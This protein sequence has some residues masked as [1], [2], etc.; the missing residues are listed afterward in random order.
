MGINPDPFTLRELA[1]MYYGRGEF[2]WGMTA[3]ISSLLININRK[4]GSAV[5][6]PLSLNPFVEKPVAY[7]KLSKTDSM[8]ALQEAFCKKSR[9]K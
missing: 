4:P 9:S 5:V 2:E 8:K 1:W 6:S 3:Y 7:I